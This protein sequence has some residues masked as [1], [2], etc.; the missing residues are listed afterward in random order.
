MHATSAFG[1]D[2]K[3]GSRR[4]N[5]PRGSV[6]DL[7]RGAG[8]VEL[9]ASLVPDGV[10]DKKPSSFVDAVFHPLRPWVAAV[11][12]KG[13]GVVWDY[14]SGEVVTEFDLGD[15]QAFD[16]DDA[17]DNEANAGEALDE[18]DGAG[19]AGVL[20]P[21]STPKGLLS[22]ATASPSTRAVQGAV[23]AGVS[24]VT[25]AKGV[26][27]PTGAVSFIKS[28]RNRQTLRML[29]YDHE[30]IACTTQLA[31]PRTC[32]DEWLVILT[33][34]RV[35][36]C[37]L[38]QNGAVHTQVHHLVCITL[39]GRVVTWRV[40]LN[41]ATASC[42]C[43]KTSETE[44]KDAFR[45]FDTASGVHELKFHPQHDLMTAACRDGTVFFLD[46]APLL[47][48]NKPKLQSIVTLP[49][50]Q[51]GSIAALSMGPLNSTLLVSELVAK[52][53]YCGKDNTPTSF[54][55]FAVSNSQE[56]RDLRSFFSQP[57][58]ELV[59]KLTR[60]NTSSAIV[61][62]RPRFFFGGSRASAASASDEATDAKQ[63]RA[64]ARTL[65]LSVYDLTGD[66][67][68]VEFVETSFASGED[69]VLH[70]FSGPLL[71]IVKYAAVSD[72]AASPAAGEDGKRSRD[73]P[74]SLSRIQRAQSYML[75]ALSS[76]KTP[77][78]R[79]TMGS[80]AN[81]SS[82]SLS[83]PTAA[84][85]EALDSASDLAK[86]YLE[87]YEWGAAAGSAEGETVV[88]KLRGGFAVDCPLTLEWESASRSFCA[89]VYPSAIKI[90][91][92]TASTVDGEGEAAAM[93][94]LHEISTPSPALSLLWVHHTLFFSTEDEV[95]CCVVS[96]TR[97]FTLALAS[98]WV[99]NEASC[100]THLSDDDLNQFPR[101]QVF[102]AGATT[103]LGVREQQL[104]LGG[105][106]QTVHLLDLSNR[107]LQCALLIT[108]GSADQ[109][110][111]MA[112]SLSP[113]AVE[114]VG[115]VFEAF[116]FVD[117]A[118]RLLPGLSLGLKINMCIKHVVLEPLT[119]LLDELLE[120]EQGRDSPS[121]SVSSAAEDWGAA[122][123]AAK[124][125]TSSSRSPSAVTSQ[126]ETLLQQW[127][128]SIAK[129]TA[130]WRTALEEQGIRPPETLRLISSAAKMT[131][132]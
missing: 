77:E 10:S 87:F 33:P 94:C 132:A 45:S 96:R 106:L 52:G 14:E 2:A 102:P 11:E 91:R 44:L 88:S 32:F 125:K 31:A 54:A 19:V 51:K 30:A 41:A 81:A 80:P 89:L 20:S 23:T 112:Q 120:E 37:D 66:D 59:R 26:L 50:A 5:L 131:S 76:P 130:G 7:Q 49:G 62:R 95:K 75:S 105:P 29:F 127:N 56:S 84:G 129:P 36:L 4:P 25:A 8:C 40:T 65:T 71:G 100:A 122:F 13:F 1:S 64:V 85:T 115:A 63:Q 79:L 123:H 114:W 92:I 99:L 15:S 101:P 6:D 39:D 46:V 118:L 68:Q 55:E 48:H 43:L 67:A 9:L 109:A 110:A 58:K 24:A 16:D 103:V 17:H 34:A 126:Q 111:Q 53:R 21:L 74:L 90:Y 28:S 72:G 98:R 82:A 35:V 86:T 18:Q 116:G 47:D 117:E 119:K 60:S 73:S 57:P 3:A 12:I 27:S 128:A 93:E 70:I 61:T 121:L 113:E 83:S 38:G 104:V 22:R 97:C 42:D 107:V 108:T 78:G 69:R 124:A